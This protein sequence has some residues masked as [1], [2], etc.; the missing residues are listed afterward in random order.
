MKKFVFAL[1]VFALVLVS[2]TVDTQQE[3]I[4]QDSTTVKIENVK[5]DTTIIT[6]DSLKSDT[7]LKH[8]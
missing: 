5:V 4:T 7:L 8:K 6:K 3:N 1:L 2:C